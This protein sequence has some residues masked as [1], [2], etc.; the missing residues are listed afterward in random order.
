MSEFTRRP[1][2]MADWVDEGKPLPDFI[3]GDI[4]A[5][6]ETRQ[7]A[8]GPEGV[9]VTPDGT[10]TVITDS[11]FQRVYPALDAIDPATIDPTAVKRAALRAD[12]AVALADI[13]KVPGQARSPEGR[14]ITALAGLVG[15]DNVAEAPVVV[16]NAASPAPK[17]AATGR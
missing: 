6:L 13:R 3:A 15:L 9:S 12:L 8:I 17:K 16:A 1:P 4:Q 7:V 14:A 2:K 11:P 5:F 10:V